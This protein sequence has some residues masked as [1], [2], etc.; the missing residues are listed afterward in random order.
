MLASSLLPPRL[1]VVHDLVTPGA[2]VAD[3]GCDHCLLGI[4]LANSG[5]AR[6]V[7]AC[8]ASLHALAK[9]G[10]NI[11]MHAIQPRA[12][13]CRLSD[14]FDALEPHEVEE[15]TMTGLG[16]PKIIS[17]LNKAGMPCGISGLV[18]QP[19]EP[20]LTLLAGLRA[21]LWAHGFM[22]E[23]ERYSQDQNRHYLTIRAKART[24]EHGGL[25]C[26]RELLLGPR[27]SLCKHSPAHF[28]GF[29]TEQRCLIAK[30]MIGMQRGLAS[31]R[32]L[33]G[34]EGL[35][36]REKLEQHERWSDFIDE[37]IR[38]CTRLL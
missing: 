21:T 36:L 38:W 18:L 16:L 5:T 14:G 24:T 22:V 4:A 34:A 25:P 35:R 30:E 37:Q 26:E 6:H 20:R 32:D 3:I 27:S 8:D 19:V 9:A 10:K 2:R 17:I 23:R 13:D 7:I 12:I 15:C 31:A 33:S 11:E 28:A 29:L 1:Q